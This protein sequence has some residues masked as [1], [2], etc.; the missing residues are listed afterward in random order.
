MPGM[1]QSD[2]MM[3]GWMSGLGL[4]LPWTLLVMAAG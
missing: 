2:G 1:D 4:V 3:T